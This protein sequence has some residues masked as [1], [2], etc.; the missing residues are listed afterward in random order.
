MALLD[1]IMVRELAERH[2]PWPRAIVDDD[3]WNDAINHLGAGRCTLP[4]VAPS[5]T[6]GKV[7]AR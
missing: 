4:Y 7:Y 3:G 5:R 6:R 2:S 1:T